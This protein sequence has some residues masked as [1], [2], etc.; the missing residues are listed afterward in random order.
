MKQS[1][2]VEIDT[3]DNDEG[4]NFSLDSNDIKRYISWGFRQQMSNICWRK[5]GIIVTP[6]PLETNEL[7]SLPKAEDFSPPSEETHKENMQV[8]GLNT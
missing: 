2:I 1:F 5:T 6:N 4:R 8:L 3:P 7:Q